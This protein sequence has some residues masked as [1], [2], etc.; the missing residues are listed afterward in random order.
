M[1]GLMQGQ[2]GSPM[3][4]QYGNSMQN[5]LTYNALMA[6]QQ[7]PQR[8]NNG[9][10]WVQGIEGAKAFQMPPNSN[11]ILL[12]SETDGRFYIKTADNIGMSTLRLFDYTEVTT[13]P[14]PPVDM[15]QYITR[16]ELN[17]ILKKF[18]GNER[19]K[20]S[21]PAVKPKPN[22]ESK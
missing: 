11:A 3:M 17:E 4:P 12:D 5:P 14:T 16:D 13:S 10:I 8:M 21:V 15:S 18:G 19:G 20:Q 1:N 7:M 22:T 2:M 6:Q 9:I